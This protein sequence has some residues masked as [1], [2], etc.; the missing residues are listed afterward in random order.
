S[1]PGIAPHLRLIAAPNGRR[2]HR[3]NCLRKSRTKDE[4]HKKRRGR[5]HHRCKFIHPIPAQKHGIS[6]MQRHLCQ[7]TAHKR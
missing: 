3:Q 2:N 4:N 5:Q 7:M 6:N 1:H